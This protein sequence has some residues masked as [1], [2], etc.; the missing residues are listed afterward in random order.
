LRATV[1]KLGQRVPLTGPPIKGVE[2]K[3]SSA[4]AL[5][6]LVS[7]IAAAHEPPAFPVPV[8]FS[9]SGKKTPAEKPAT[10]AIPAK[11]PRPL[12]APA[13]SR[14]RSRRADRDE[15]EYED[16]EDAVVP[17]RALANTRPATK[18]IAAAEAGGVPGVDAKAVKRGRLVVCEST[19]MAWT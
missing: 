17:T 10:A 15:D 13:R 4:A 7:E 16:D 19:A 8:K 3:R 2:P 11:P 1:V 6:P 18:K 5:I 9:A 14:V 12:P